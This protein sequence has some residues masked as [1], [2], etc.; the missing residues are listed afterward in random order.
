MKVYRH[1]SEYREGRMH[2]WG[3]SEHNPLH[4]YC[5]FKKNPELIRTSLEDLIPW[6]KWPA[7]EKFFE[8]IEWLNSEYSV[9]ETN[10]CAFV[11]PKINIDNKF[12]K[13]HQCSGRLMILYRDLNFN[14]SKGHIDWLEGAVHHYFMQT[15]PEFEWGVVGTSLLNTRYV[16][17]PL[18]EEN[19][20]GTELSI[21]FW[22]WGDGEG[23]C[24]SN[25]LR[26]FKNM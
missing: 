16:E 19:Q 2:P 14:I 5:D 12:A 23:E 13:S 10:D 18:P 15:D 4:R 8:M 20:Y 17:L 25:C 22:A 6:S 1:P 9:F 7:I 21:E 26:L 24:M 3:I 11:G